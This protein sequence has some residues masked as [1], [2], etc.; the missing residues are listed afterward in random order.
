MKW[1]VLGAVIQGKARL[2]SARAGYHDVSLI[3]MTALLMQFRAELWKLFAR[4]RTYMGFVAFLALEALLLGLSYLRGVEGF[5]RNIITRQGEAFEYYFSALTIGRFVVGITV[6]LVGA[7]FVCLVSGDIVA[8]ESED[9]Q[10]RMLFARPISRLR[11]LGVKYV[12]VSFYAVFMVQFIMWTALLLGV[13]QRGWGGGLFAWDPAIG[14]MNFMDG[15]EGLKRYAMASVALGLAMTAISSVGFCLSCMKIK[16]AAATIAALAYLFID[17]VVLNSGLMRSYQH[18]LITGYI[19]SWAQ[20]FMDPIPWAQMA[21]SY[22]VLLAANLSL[23]T[24]GA[25]MFQGRDL[26]S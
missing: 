17:M 8:K 12:T 19:R 16:P 15:E 2:A 24:L 14:L 7:L 9:G 23:F 20:I 26:K 4:K 11:L 10:M 6:A 1:S 3:F 18:F 22:S 5:W 25:A 13:T 21:R